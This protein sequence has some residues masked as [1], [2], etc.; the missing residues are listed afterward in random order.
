MI[1]LATLENATEQEVFDQAVKHLLFQNEK[2]E[3]KYG[4][5]LYRNENLK[6][7]AG[8]FISDN[9]YKESFEGCTWTNLVESKQV[10]DKHIN[11]IL[12]LQL[13][14][15]YVEVEKWVENLIKLG[16]DFG[17]KFNK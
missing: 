5:C 7:V 13:I 6:C 10:T 15:D 17:L 14:H 16:A 11:L 4:E 8:C 1:T 9:E 12:K 2:S 3:S